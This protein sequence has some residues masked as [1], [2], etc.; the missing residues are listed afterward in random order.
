MPLPNPAPSTVSSQLVGS[1]PAVLDKNFGSGML[2]QFN[3]AVQKDMKGNAI[4]VAY[5]G[6]LGRHLSNGFDI[7]R[8]PPNTSGS[9]TLRRFYSQLP[10]V[11]TITE[12]FSEGAS[13]YHS[14]QATFERRFSNGLGFNV[15]TTWAHLTDDA[16]NVNGQSGNGVGQILSSSNVDDYGNG[17]LDTRSRVVVTG[18]YLLPF[19][20]GTHGFRNAIE[21]G[22]HL[23]VLNLWST[24]LPF[25]VLNASNISNTS[26][27]GSADRPNVKG[28]P[29]SN[30]TPISNFPQFF[31]ATAFVTQPGGILGNERRNQLHGPHFRHWDMSLF[32][33]FKV[34]RETTLQFRVEAFNIANQ[35]NFSNPT[36]SLG[37]AA[38][39]G[40][41]TSTLPSYQP[42]LIQLALKYQ[43]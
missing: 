14:L 41:L 40:A 39:F 18:N 36:S 8:A 27:N 3:M 7:N 31:R 10:G 2:E 4:T 35:A 32:K 11:T 43:F 26:P 5:V 42:R 38:T 15:N 30:V 33:D 21:G 1:I 22:W 29:F 13:S 9:Q 12:T 28:D 23:N 6:A 19:G 37:T 24:G 16:P 17:D 25:T 34:Y 20:K